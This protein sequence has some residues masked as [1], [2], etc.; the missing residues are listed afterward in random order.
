MSLNIKEAM[1]KYFDALETLYQEKTRDLS[2]IPYDSEIPDTIY[3]GETTQDSWIQWK[4][5][6]KNTVTSLTQLELQ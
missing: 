1:K 5:M 2:Y 4:A 6:E 3:V